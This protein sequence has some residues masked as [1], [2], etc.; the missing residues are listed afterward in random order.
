LGGLNGWEGLDLEEVS[1]DG[2][3]GRMLGY[4]SVDLSRVRLG[5]R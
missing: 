5:G 1:E 2:G 3:V 4:R